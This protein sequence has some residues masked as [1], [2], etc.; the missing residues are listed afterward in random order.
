[1]MKLVIGLVC[2]FCGA[3]AAGQAWAAEPGLEDY[4]QANAALYEELSHGKAP[5]GMSNPDY[6]RKVSAAFDVRVIAT[7]KDLPGVLDICDPATKT[8]TAYLMFGLT[9]EKLQ[10]AQGGAELARLEMENYVRFQDEIFPAMRFAAACAAT[11]AEKG[12]VFAGQLKPQDMTPIRRA[13]FQ[14]MQHGL[15]ATVYG[16]A[17]SVFD[18]VKPEYRMVLLDAVARSIDVLSAAMNRQ[19]RQATAA[20]VDKVL[21]RPDLPPEAKAKLGKVRQALNRPDCNALCS[22]Q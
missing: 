1:M 16:A 15:V 18:Q 4:K 17:L 7:A 5:V 22:L 11:T 9:K 10:G 21:A 14:Q 2:L 12:E 19:A 13:A 3:I 20:D 6:A 8:R